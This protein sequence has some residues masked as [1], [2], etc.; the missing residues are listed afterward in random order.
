MLEREEVRRSVLQSQGNSSRVLT[1]DV[2]KRRSKRRKVYARVEG[3][4]RDSRG[5]GGCGCVFECRRECR[6]YGMRRDRKTWIEQRDKASSVEGRGG[7]GAA[8]LKDLFLALGDSTG[9]LAGDLA[10]DLERRR[11]EVDERLYLRPD[12]WSYS[13]FDA[14]LRCISLDFRRLFQTREVKLPK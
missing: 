4:T 9:D 7:D 14:D 1:G 6:R 12:K 2:D 5:G 3:P 11:F 10:G 13:F 8:G